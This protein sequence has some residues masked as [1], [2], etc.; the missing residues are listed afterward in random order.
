MNQA[1]LSQIE[2]KIFEL[3][4]DEQLTLIARV[5]EKLREKT[6]GAGDFESQLSEMANDEDIRRELMEIETGFR[7]TEFDGLEKR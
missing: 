2:Q 7:H 4:V 5:A 1:A 6:V 3:S